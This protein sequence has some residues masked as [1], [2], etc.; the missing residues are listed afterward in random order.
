LTDPQRPNLVGSTP[1]PGR[2]PAEPIAKE[3]TPA[4]NAAAANLPAREWVGKFLGRYQINGILG[5]GGMGVVLKGYDPVIDRDVAI[6]ILADELAAVPEARVRFLA[7]AKAAGKL[8]HPNVIAI[9]EICQQASTFFL[10]LEYAP[11]GSVDDQITASGPLAALE[12]TRALMDACKGVGAAHAAGLIHRDIKPGNFMRAAD[13]SI[14]VADFGLAK[15]TDERALHLTRTGL[16]VGTP[17][18]MSPEQCEAKPVDHRSDIYSLGGAYYCLLTARQ[19]YQEAGNVTQA[20]YLHCHGPIPDPRAVNPS[21]PEACSRIVARAMGKAPAERYQSTGEMLADLQALNATLSGLTPIALPSERNAVPAP[22]ARG[23]SL[24]KEDLSESRVLIVDDV[25]AN[26]DVLVQALRG[27]Y[28]ISVAL[29]GESAIRTAEKTPPDLVLLD[30]LMPGIDG[31]EVCR[32]L[33]CAAA[34]AEVPIMFLSS[35]E[36]VGSKALGFEVGAND[37]LTK[38]FEILEVKA[39]VRSHLKARAFS[40]AVKEQ[41][42]SELRIAREIQHGILPSDIA[43]HTQGTGLEIGAVLEP[44][45]EVGGD[46]YEVVRLED[47]RV[48]VA[49]G[50]VS[51]KGI[52]AALFMAVAT[53]LIR[54]MA[55]QQKSPQDI[56]RQVS[57]ALAAQN[58]RN[59]FVTLFCATFD[60]VKGLMTC[61]NAGHLSP[62][63]IRSG[64]APSLPFPASALVAGVFPGMEVGSQT[65]QLHPGDTLVLYTDG[66]TEAFNADKEMF[67]ESRL[68]KQLAREPGHSAAETVA[69]VL[70]AVRQ[71]AGA[72][73]QSDDITILA[74]RYLGA[75]EGKGQRER[76]LE[77]TSAVDAHPRN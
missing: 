11:G 14:K 31:Y 21:V 5:E 56:V 54:M 40:L 9:Y 74:V 7:E 55:H 10:V 18:F 25:K 63:L 38:P 43:S 28:K 27:D 51:G 61:A 36:E 52:P 69:N 17:F 19:P 13:G 66:V 70:K 42:A 29:N 4:G 49:V 20:M 75:P 45:K 71:H 16:I 37:Y 30:I 41:M 62:V 48:V 12:A 24:M 34:T 65:M 22:A 68:L 72:S 2:A 6:K 23:A 60:P 58:P 76:E 59:M 8:N 47:G 26:V 32:R 67:L 46:L 44:A 77:A 50:D 1:L 73:P 39:R 64:H 57:D 35:L 3:A 53:T 33:R 15:V